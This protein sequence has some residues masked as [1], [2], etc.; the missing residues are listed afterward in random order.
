MK[1][2]IYKEGEV[3]LPKWVRPFVQKSISEGELPFLLV[4]TALGVSKSGK[5]KSDSIAIATANLQKRGIL[6]KHSNGL[7]LLGYLSEE[8]K[9][10]ELGQREVKARIK[11]FEALK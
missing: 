8:A 2:P 10:A 11:A 1:N 5:S 3:N 6:V 7:T 4:N 9:L